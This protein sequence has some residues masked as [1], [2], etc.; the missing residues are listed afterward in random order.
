[1]SRISFLFPSYLLLLI[2][3]PLAVFVWA[4]LDSTS[5]KLNVLMASAFGLGSVLVAVIGILLAIFDSGNLRNTKAGKPFLVMVY[6][7]CSATVASF[8]V[9]LASLW[10]GS[11]G[12][13]S[14]MREALPYVLIASTYTVVVGVLAAVI[15]IVG[16]W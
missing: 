3:I 5:A 2:G 11:G 4:P 10:L 14:I 8:F 1:M 16:W 7:L 12:T 15:Q 13:P 9:G 6:M